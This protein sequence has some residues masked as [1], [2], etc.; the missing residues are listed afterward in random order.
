MIARIGRRFVVAAVGIYQFRHV[1]LQERLA[2]TGT[3]SCR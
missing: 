2:T 1:R 3:L